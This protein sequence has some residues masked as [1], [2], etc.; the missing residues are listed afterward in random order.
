MYVAPYPHT[1]SGSYQG[2]A[3]LIFCNHQYWQVPSLFCLS[4]AFSMGIFNFLF[5]SSGFIHS[6]FI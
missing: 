2:L 5:I 4:L 1:I 6:E 3:F